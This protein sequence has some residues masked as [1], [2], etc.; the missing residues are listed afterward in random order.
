MKHAF[1]HLAGQS[2][3]LACH[4]ACWHAKLAHWHVSTPSWIIGTPLARW[5]VDTEAKL[6]RMA[7]MACDLANVYTLCESANVITNITINFYD[8]TTLHYLV[9]KEKFEY[10]CVSEPY[11]VWVAVSEGLFWVNV[12]YFGWVGV[13]GKMFWVGGAGWGWVHFLIMPF[14][15]SFLCISL[16]YR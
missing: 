10:M 6:A 7:C 5:H 14:S 2:E 9:I 8:M 4:L 13:G 3:K 12:G 1:W 15:N 11:F 16:R